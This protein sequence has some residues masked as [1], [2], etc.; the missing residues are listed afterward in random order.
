MNYEKIKKKNLGGFT[1]IEILTSIA[2]FSLIAGGASGVFISAIRAQRKSLSNQELLSQTSYLMEYMSRTIRMAKKDTEGTCISS[3]L[4]YDITRDGEGIKFLNYNGIC[5][6]FYL[7]GDRLKEEKSGITLDLISSSL[8]VES[9]NIG[10]KDSWDQWDN[11]QPRV[12]FFLKIKGA[13]EKAE[14]Q[15]EIQI[16]TTISQRNLD[17]QY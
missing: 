7:S 8:K 5:Q 3:G 13:G 2:I 14:L 17:T 6:E 9:F 1:L 10:P 16:Q 12:T 4:N 15:P 11:E